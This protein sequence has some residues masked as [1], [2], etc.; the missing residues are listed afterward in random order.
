M[1]IKKYIDINKFKVAFNGLKIVFKEES[2]FRYQFFILLMV[3][4]VGLW[5]GLNSIEWLVIIGVSATVFTFEIMN[6]AVENIIDIL[7]PNYH[8]NAKK[9]KDIS[10]GAVLVAALGAL[11][12]G[13]FIFIPKLIELI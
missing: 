4:V 11:I 13:L 5:L 9:I 2:S 3:V 6:T 8:E 1:N 12:I 10:A 7:Y